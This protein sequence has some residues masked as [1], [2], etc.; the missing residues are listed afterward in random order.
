MDGMHCTGF[1]VSGYL[2]GLAKGWIVRDQ[3]I[4]HSPFSMCGEMNM[5]L[6]LACCVD[7]LLRT[8]SEDRFMTIY[9]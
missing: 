2:R 3:G 5:M 8:L 1:G 7:A 4:V 6:N 9:V